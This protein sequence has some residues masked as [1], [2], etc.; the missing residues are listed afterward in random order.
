MDSTTYLVMSA[1]LLWLG[2]AGLWLARVRHDARSSEVK[3]RRTE[4]MRGLRQLE[5]YL[6]RQAQ[7]ADYVRRQG[8]ARK[9]TDRRDDAGA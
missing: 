3:P 9:R 8:S 6:E 2:L 4:V 5:L 1:P 7:F